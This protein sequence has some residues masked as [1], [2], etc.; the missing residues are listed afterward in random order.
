MDSGALRSGDDFWHAA[1]IFQH[2]DT[3]ED[4]LLAH[5]LA[6]VAAAHGRRDAAWIAAASLDRYLMRIGRKQVYGTQFVT[7]R[8]GSTTQEPYDRTTVSDALRIATGVPSLPFQDVQLQ[9]MEARNRPAVP[10]CA[11]PEVNCRESKAPH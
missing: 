4:Y 8:G 7:P 3:P 5:S 1:F 10:P 6:I 2:G 9:E 11:R